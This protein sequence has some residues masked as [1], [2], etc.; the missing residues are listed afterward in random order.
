MLKG[1]F[2]GSEAGRKRRQQGCQADERLIVEENEH[3]RGN[4][5]G[6]RHV[7]TRDKIRPAWLE[8]PSALLEQA[9]RGA[10]KV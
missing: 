8:G 2:F 5:Q 4:A 10:E 3:A 9:W 6:T 7:T 1:R